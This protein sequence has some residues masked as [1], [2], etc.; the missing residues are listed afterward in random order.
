MLN[1]TFSKSQKPSRLKPQIYNKGRKK[2]KTISKTK[3]T[4]PKNQI[5]ILYPKITNKSRPVK[6]ENHHPDAKIKHQDEKPKGK[7]SD[8]NPTRHEIDRCIPRDEE[9]STENNWIKPQKQGVCE[10]RKRGR[11]RER[12]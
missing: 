6:S 11:R 10:D 7:R 3:Q 4:K 9:H 12:D 5:E 2:L 1:S 8:R